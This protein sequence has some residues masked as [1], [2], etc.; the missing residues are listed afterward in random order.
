[1]NIHIH[2]KEDDK[3]VVEKFGIEADIFTID[4]GGQESGCYVWVTMLQL[5][6][7]AIS[8]ASALEEKNEK[9]RQSV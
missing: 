8:I 7:L 1:M 5:K 9:S 3:M 4:I 6:K 2:T